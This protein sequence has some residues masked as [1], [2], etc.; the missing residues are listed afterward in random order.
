[1]STVEEIKQAIGQ[2]SAQE[3]ERLIEWLYSL[4]LKPVNAV[5]ESIAASE[6]DV[7]AGRVLTQDEAK[8]RLAFSN[9]R[10]GRLSTRQC[11]ELAGL[12]RDRFMDELARHRIEAP[13]TVADLDADV[14]SLDRLERP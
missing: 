2:L 12:S 13:Y 3:Q 8:L 10:E 4:E 9:Y 1:M 14:A 11:A 5:M 6:I 7:A